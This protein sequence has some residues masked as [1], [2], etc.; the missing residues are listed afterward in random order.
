MTKARERLLSALLSVMAVVFCLGF[1]EVALRLAGTGERM[2]ST[3]R[4]VASGWTM[5]LD[6]YPTNPRGYFDIDLRTPAA[7]EKYR[8]VAPGRFENVAAR[9]PFAV[10]FRYN[11]LKFRERELDA[12]RPGVRRVM[13]LG[14]SFTE[15]QGVK[16]PDTLVRV[17]E[18]KLLERE[19]GR[20]EVLNCGR[21]G[22]DFPELYGALED[23][24]PFAPDLVVYAMVLNDGA[25]SPEFQARQRYV[26]DWILDRGAMDF[27][28]SE[29]APEEGLFRSRLVGFV[30]DRLEKRRTA[31]ETT[32]WYR[33][34]YG[35]P[36]RSG[37]AQTQQHMRDMQRRL[38][39][40]GAQLLVAQWPLLV[41]LDGAYPFEEVDRTIA[42][43]CLQ[44]GIPRV[45]LRPA[46]AGVRTEDLWVHPLDMHPNETA[47]RKAAEALVEPVR[48]ALAAR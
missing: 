29:R 35:E 23:I 10:E 15:G 46:L 9:A 14:D 28:G 47:Q 1:A 20:W 12:P 8:R 36:N 38:R 11:H 30:R 2:R 13:V 25:R 45:D 43:F 4:L 7:R 21:R 18:R 5:L 3:A 31:E 26:N 44:A 22:T 42:A 40:Q 48:S 24:L 37:W 39:E 34:M 19:P 27:A 41:G 33:D 17:L 16:E 6:C 32:R